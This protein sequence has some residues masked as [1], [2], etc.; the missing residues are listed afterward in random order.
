[1]LQQG[2]FCLLQLVDVYTRPACAE[3]S[4]AITSAYTT[5]SVVAHVLLRRLVHYVYNITLQVSAECGSGEAG[6]AHHQGVFP[7]AGSG[8]LAG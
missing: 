5:I 1:M 4:P 7:G 3:G 8:S 2:L 6:G